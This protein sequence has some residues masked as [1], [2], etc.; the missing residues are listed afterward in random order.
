MKCVL[1]FLWGGR[2]GEVVFVCVIVIFVLC[3]FLMGGGGIIYAGTF[4]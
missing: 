2:G 1:C 3:V 4:L